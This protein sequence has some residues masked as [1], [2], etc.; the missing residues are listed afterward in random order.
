M[1][2]EVGDNQLCY[3]T[4]C[5]PNSTIVDSSTCVVASAPTEQRGPDSVKPT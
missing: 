5:Q 3:R 4:H 2:T 1:S